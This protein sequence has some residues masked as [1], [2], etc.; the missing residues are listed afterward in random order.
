MNYSKIITPVEYPLY[1][2]V[3]NYLIENNIN[4]QL[5]NKNIYNLNTI[6]NHLG[7]DFNSGHYTSFH[8]IQDKWFLADDEDIRKIPNNNLFNNNHKKNAYILIYEKQEFNE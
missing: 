1:L 2:D 7:S 8:K 4:K 3:D 5:N 6:I